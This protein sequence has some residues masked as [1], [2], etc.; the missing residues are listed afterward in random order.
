MVNAILSP[1]LYLKHSELTN[2]GELIEVLEFITDYLEIGFNL[3]NS[4]VLHESNWY[5]V[6]K[7]KPTVYNQFTT[8]VVPLLKKLY[9]RTEIVA[10]IEEELK[11]CIPDD[12]YLITDYEEF[13]F[14]LDS[15]YTC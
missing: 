6:P 1:C 12:Q 2:L 5:S 10:T 7:Y 15:V 3:S 13:K 9:S 8:F 14:M 11:Y 4:S